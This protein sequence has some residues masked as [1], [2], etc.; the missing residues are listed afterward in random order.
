MRAW[1]EASTHKK[2]QTV[3][4]GSRLRSEGRRPLIETTQSPICPDR[5]GAAA[6]THGTGCVVAYVGLIRKHSEGG[7][8]LSVEYRDPEGNAAD[9]QRQAAAEAQKR[10]P[11]GQIDIVHRMS[12]EIRTLILEDA[13]A[14]AQRPARLALEDELLCS[15]GG[16]ATA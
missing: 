1:S 5:V 7:A 3:G 4:G 14:F 10:W 2:G 6:S 8:V 13:S 9:V 12:G 16:P 11:G 15:G